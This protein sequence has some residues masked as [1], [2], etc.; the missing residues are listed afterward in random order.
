MKFIRPFLE[1]IINPFF[2]T[3]ILFLGCLI[4]LTRRGN[5]RAVKVG[6]LMVF[7]CLLTFSTA[8]LP[9]YLTKQLEGQYTPILEPNPS[10][11]RIVVLGGGQ[12]QYANSPSNNLLT[13][14]STRRLMEGVRLYRLLPG[15][16]LILSGGNFN[17]EPSEASRMFDLTQW[18][19]IPSKD[20]VLETA[21]INTADQA[22]E[23][24]QLL[25]GQSFYL[26]TSAIHMPRSMALFQKQG[27]T[28]IAAPTD[29]TF[30]WS[31]ERWEKLFFPNP[32]N[33][34]YLNIAW[35]E[36]LGRIWANLT[37]II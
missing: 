28:P 6:F 33:F 32:K 8:F 22:R 17:G 7:I 36:I 16:K 19:E 24:K 30:Y 20:I 11:Q 4:V 29:F 21:S 10:I 9:R 31:D 23:L 35:H 12:Y 2:L 26:V 37:G 14:A 5:S 27:L 1:A 13:S 34:A 25:K 18:F 15:S 3:V